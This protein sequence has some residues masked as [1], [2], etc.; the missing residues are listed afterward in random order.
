AAIPAFAQ[1]GKADSAPATDKAATPADKAWAELET[2]L[3]GPK[4]QPKSAEEA[5]AV[6][7]EYLAELDAKAA[8]FIK[9]NPN[10]AR[11]WKLA[12]NEVQSPAMRR[13]AG[14][15]VDKEAMKKLAA[16]IIA[17]PDADKDSKG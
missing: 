13:F 1:Q 11:R 12:A 8:A 5:K 6:Y 3:K 2:L 7:K 10:D 16:D 14:V 4:K 15:P 17:A 9:D